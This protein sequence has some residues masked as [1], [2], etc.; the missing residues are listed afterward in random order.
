M[1]L[2]SSPAQYRKSEPAV[3]ATIAELFYHACA[4][5]L[6]DA[7]AFKRD[8]RFVPISHRQVQAAVERLALALRARGLAAG[9][10][11][12]IISENRPEWALA[13]YACAVS[14]CISVPVYPTLNGPQTAFVLRHSG[15]RWVFCSTPEQARKVLAQWEGL[16]DLE[17]VVLMEGAEEAPGRCI[18]PWAALQAEGEGMEERR[19]EVAQWAR[20]RQP[21]DL[22]TLVYTSGTTGDPK[23]AMLTHGNLARNIQDTVAVVPVRKGDLSLSFL[24]L[25]HVFE[26]MAGHF[27]LF[28]VGARIAYAESVATVVPDLQLLQPTIL[29]AV[30]RVYEKI[31]AAVRESVS[32]SSLLKRFVFHWALE[33]GR[34]AVPYLYEDR[35]L[36][37]GI[38]LKLAVSRRLVFRKILARTGG[39]LRFGGSGGAPLAP[40]LL[41][42]FWAIGL[43]VLEGYGLTETSPVV[44]F[45]R[46]GEIAPGKVGRPLYDSWEGRP[47][48][49]LA[50]D[51]E[52]LCQ[53]PNIM[54]GY[55][56]NPEA[57]AEAIGADGYFR[58]GDIGEMD[59]R[60]RLKITDRKKELIITSGGKNVAPQPI[61]ELL[62]T[63]K[64][65]AQAVVIGDGRHY[66]TAVL[67]PNFPSLHRWAG[68]KGLDCPG[69]ADLAARPEVRTKL[70]QR[71]E[72]VNA[73]LSNYERIR[74]VCVVAREFTL[75]SGEL[76]PSLKVKRRVI[77][78]LYADR[79]EAMYRENGA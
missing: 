11:V 1:L 14:G 61:E 44:A 69:D 63:D 37:L 23:G 34:Q 5:D 35:P 46:L 74:K 27:A 16:P 13:D 32:A 40:H 19:P 75:D 3:V 59:G 6:P 51:G 65:I 62:K 7:L 31:H 66:L 42:F 39:R 47:F 21:G 50:P 55:W 72:R 45:N 20:E 49:V 58:T 53:G 77:N 12:A 30:P 68:Y 54:A 9:D 79:I 8:G 24:P 33:A 29:L 10:R 71:V 73:Q 18:L 25:S 57:T 78:E 52:I 76:T 4:H 17:A 22:L 36:P 15:S 60:G 2:H 48:V 56:R 28:F 41:E 26:R 38:R 67:V 43:P 64:Y 70:M